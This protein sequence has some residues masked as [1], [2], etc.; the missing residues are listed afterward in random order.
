M[1]KMFATNGKVI[2]LMATF[3]GNVKEHSVFL[4]AL[5]IL[6]VLLTFFL[7]SVVL[8]M[9]TPHLI[10]GLKEVPTLALKAAPSM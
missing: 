4:L 1:K 10:D 2:T 5:A 8:G 6:A 3:I 7:V 9:P